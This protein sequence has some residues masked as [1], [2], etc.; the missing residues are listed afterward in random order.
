[1]QQRVSLQLIAFS[2]FT[3]FV[4]FRFVDVLLLKHDV[5]GLRVKVFVGLQEVL[6]CSTN[7]NV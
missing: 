6:T 5:P 2:I 3:L 4:R 1:M 7:S